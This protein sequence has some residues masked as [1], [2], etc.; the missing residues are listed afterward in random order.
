MAGIT[1]HFHLWPGIPPGSFV[2]SCC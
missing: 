2:P 1:G